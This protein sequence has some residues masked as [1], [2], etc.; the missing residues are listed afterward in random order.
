[1]ALGKEEFEEVKNTRECNGAESRTWEDKR[2]KE[3]PNDK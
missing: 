1:M 2:F 3:K